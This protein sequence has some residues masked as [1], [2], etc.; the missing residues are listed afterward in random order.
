MKRI[1][2]DLETLATS[3][4]ALII[5]IGAVEFDEAGLGWEFYTVVNQYPQVGKWG[6]RRDT[7]TEKWWSEQG[8]TAKAVLTESLPESRAPDLESA[9][10]QFSEYVAVVNGG[11]PGL[12]A[13]A[14][15]GDNPVYKNVEMWGNGADF[16]CVILGSA[17]EATGLTRPWSYSNNRCY[18]T[19][20]NLGIKL[21]P[22]TGTAFQGTKHNALDDAKYQAH[23][24]A[25]WLRKI[26]EM[27]A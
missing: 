26:K 4:D 17:Y 15:T 12:T 20:K 3:S 18:R 16:D 25:A 6:R 14:R 23:Y 7:K 1:M 8:D 21:D 19:L 11:A 22:G 10:M 2:M 27:P 5:S 9:L 13:T 24:A